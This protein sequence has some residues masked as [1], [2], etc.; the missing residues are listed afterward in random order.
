MQ[1]RLQSNART[2]TISK[3]V[4]QYNDMKGRLDL[5]TALCA[6]MQ[7]TTMPDMDLTP[8]NLAL[9][10]GVSSVLD[11]LF[12]IIADENSSALIPAPMYPMFDVDLGVRGGVHV[13]PVHLLDCDD[14]IRELDNAFARAQSARQ[15]PRALLLTN[16]DNPTGIV[17]SEARIKAMLRW[18]V[19]KRVHCVVDECYC[20]S[21]FPPDAPFKSALAM[22]AEVAAELDPKGEEMLWQ[23]V[24]VLIGMSKDFCASGA[25]ELSPAKSCAFAQ[26]QNLRLE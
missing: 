4:L 12:F 2:S 1:E 6:L 7:R 5:R 13:H 24:H 19:R 23:L 15:P 14:D 16:P 8:E 11:N 26:W 22:A 17:Y 9:S 18:C 10:A 25:I 20:W 21:T 3:D